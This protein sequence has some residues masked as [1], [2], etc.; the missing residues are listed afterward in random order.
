MGSAVVAIVAGVVF[1]LEKVKKRK[2]DSP[3][4]SKTEMPIMMVR[5]RSLGILVTGSIG[6]DS[7]GIG[8]T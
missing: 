8:D 4:I 2:V 6:S 1:S 5:E 7:A 3:I